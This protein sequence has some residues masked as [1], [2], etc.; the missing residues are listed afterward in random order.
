MLS[1][2]LLI[3]IKHPFDTKINLRDFGV[4]SVDVYIAIGIIALY[5]FVHFILYLRSFRVQI[6]LQFPF[7]LVDCYCLS[8]LL[9]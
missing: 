7:H 5:K 1:S 3:R 8:L 2:I 9:V 6:L 4:L